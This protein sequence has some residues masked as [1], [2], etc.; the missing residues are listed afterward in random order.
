MTKKKLLV[1]AFVLVL[2]VSVVILTACNLKDLGKPDPQSGEKSIKIVIGADI[3]SVQTDLEYVHQVL[4][5]LASEK[6]FSYTYSEGG[7]GVSVM[8]LKDLKTSSDWTSWISLYHDI[9]DITLIDTYGTHMY[10]GESYFM[11]LVSVDKLPVIDGSTY[12]FV[13]EQL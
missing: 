8:G 10:E 2:I 13:Q 11:S 3:Y 5:D 1:V 4:V 7:Y 9:N 12:L 6:D